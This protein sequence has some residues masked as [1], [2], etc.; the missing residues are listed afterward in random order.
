MSMIRD[1]RAAVR[2][3]LRPSLR[4]NTAPYN[5]YDPTR[6]PSASSAV[7]DCAVYRDGLRTQ[8]DS[9]LSP[10]EAMRRVREDGGFAWIGLHEPTE[11]EFAGIAAEFGLHPL[12][13][14]DAVHAHQ[15]P[16]LERYDDTLFTVFKT[17]HYVE[18]AE[19]TATSEVVETGEVM[20][21]TGRDFV[22]TVRHGGQGSLRALRKRLQDDPELLAKGPSAVLHAIADQVVDGYLAVVDA[23]QDDIDEVEID[24]FSAP[25][26]G[27]PRGTDAG[28]IYQ[29]KR[30]VLEF[31]RAV[32]PLLRPM[33]LLSERPMRLVDPDIQKYF[34]DV[35]DH[36]ARVQE[37]VVG[38]DELLNSILQA[39]LAQASFA[40][41]EDMRK[42]TS[43]AAIIAVPTMVCGV[44]GMNFDHMPELHWKYG[45]PLVLAAIA[46]SCLVIHRT[47]KRNGW[48]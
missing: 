10:R 26:K 25:S 40:Q 4:K 20:C 21:F 14:E 19:L 11:A 44:Y 41:N 1:L 18:H 47:L 39:N 17:V 15:R 31:K 36:L 24:V 2:P 30:E 16:K 37:H 6:D 13:V 28:R 22:I 33:Q 32:S 48:L 45:Y 12:A 27:S 23:M 35:A 38:F 5:S 9:C 29:L 3:S 42:I 46:G 34:R 8:A 43:W 7:V